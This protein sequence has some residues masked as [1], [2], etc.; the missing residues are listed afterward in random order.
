MGGGRTAAR[1]AAVVV[2]VVLPASAAAGSLTGI[3]VDDPV[4]AADAHFG[5]SVAG[6]GD[7][8]ADGAADFAVGAPGQGLVYIISGSTTAV[9]HSI[10]DPDNLA[11]TQCE[12]SAA[13]PSPCAFGFAV[14]RVG[15][16]D[17][18]G[19]EDVAV[20]APGVLDPGLPLPCPFPDQPCPQLGRVFIFSGASGA[21]IRRLD[22]DGPN[23]GAA[24]VGL[25]SI[26]G[27]AVPDVAAVAPGRPTGQGGL[28][29][30]F[31]GANGKEIWSTLAPGATEGIKGLT[32]A[33]AP[34]ARIADVTGD[35]TPDLLLGAPLDSNGQSFFIGRAYVVSGASGALV[36]THDNP[37]PLAGDAF[38]AGVAG[39]GDQNGDGVDDYAISEPG[40]AASPGSLVHLY[41]GAT[42]EALGAPL[43]S[44][45]DERNPPNAS[46]QS[47][48]L[49]GIDDKD[50]DGKP[51]FWLGATKTGAAF[52]LNRQGQVLE[53]AADPVPDTNFGFATSP[54]GALAG[55]SGLDVVVGAPT[56]A[57][58]TVAG[59]GAVF[60]LRPEADL[61]VSKT[62]TPPK[63]VP[64][65]TLSYTV[66]VTNEGPSTATGVEVTETIPSPLVLVPASLADDPS[67]AFDPASAEVACAVGSLGVGA[68]FGL[69]FQVGVPDDALVPSNISNQASAT[70]VTAD[71]TPANNTGSA[72]AQLG[73]DVVGSAGDDVLVGTGPGE[74]ICGLGG[75]DH[76]VG[77]GA[78]DVLVGGEGNDILHGGSGDDTLRGGSGADRLYGQA[79]ADVLAGGAG[80][81]ELFGGP[82]VDVLDGGAGTDTCKA[83]AD[84]GTVIGCESG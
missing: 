40:S 30:A 10:G 19:I 52:L 71:P 17:G 79:G 80:D 21:L 16:V 15:D 1:L 54:I 65:G 39:I 22:Q 18:D 38:G 76:L 47:M 37:T 57:V 73:C 24:V 20:G 78:N 34:F 29:A 82:G 6:T 36:R 49:S 33:S 69:D 2:A 5:L 74:S 12:P 53:T 62:V 75:D 58:G 56:R 14:G 55:E 84:G 26:N 61:R 11:G 43:P 42:G 81:D 59:A 66:T 35:G 13:D 50:E 60:L 68:S 41:S 4:P 25:G 46:R 83:Q 72:E 48:A 7:V 23:Q 27:D 63:A 32:P 45:A 28:V 67:C 3:R 70:A 44:P 8:N 51:D 77:L 9:L 64:G 31:S